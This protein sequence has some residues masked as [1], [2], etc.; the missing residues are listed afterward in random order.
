MT[1]DEKLDRLTERTDALTHSVEL[2][3]SLHRD[4]EIKADERAARLERNV[5][6]VVGIV[7]N[8]ANLVGNQEGRIRKLEGE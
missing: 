8:L 4:L 1:T 3:A 2:L 5:E 7:E 6:R